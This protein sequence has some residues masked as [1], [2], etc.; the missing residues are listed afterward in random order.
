MSNPGPSTS[1]ADADPHDA[2]K[3]KRMRYVRDGAITIAFLWAAMFW[4]CNLPPREPPRVLPL[5]ARIQL[6]AQPADSEV[7]LSW[8]VFDAPD[9]IRN[10]Q[11][12]SRLAGE[13][14]SAWKDMTKDAV[15]GRQK[16][17]GLTNG[18][19]YAFRVKFTNDYGD[20]ILSNEAIAL[21]ASYEIVEPETPPTDR[22][23]THDQLGVV[24]FALGRH[25]V[26]LSLLDNQA[27][28]A[29][30]VSKATDRVANG[31]SI[32][33]AGYASGR[34]KPA[35]NLDLSERRADAVATYL[36][37]NVR[38]LN[39]GL[40]TLAMGE[41]HAELITDRENERYQKVVVTACPSEAEAN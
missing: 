1:R 18:L 8:N 25:Q 29:R 40:V 36:R 28:L 35:Y 12:Q 17:I 39:D 16:V 31:A 4:A 23:C 15:N 19:I 26:S 6:T 32:L 5:A 33:V 27:S 38:D 10:W 22:L 2:D 14:Y 7:E 41:R 11:Y 24:E 30:I 3:K 20:D 34:G 9:N 37:N 13:S 21:P